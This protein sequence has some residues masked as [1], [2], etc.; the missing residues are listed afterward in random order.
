MQV[1]FRDQSPQSCI[2]VFSAPPLEW[3]DIKDKW[4]FKPASKGAKLAFI[5]ITFYPFL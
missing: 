3:K 5:K 4:C 2:S 1:D